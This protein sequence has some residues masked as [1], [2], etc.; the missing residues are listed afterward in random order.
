VERPVSAELV[1]FHQAEQMARL[2]GVFARPAR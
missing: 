1:R 2:R